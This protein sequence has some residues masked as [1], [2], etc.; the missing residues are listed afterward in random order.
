MAIERLIKHGATNLVVPGMPPVGCTPPVLAVFDAN[1][2]QARYNPQTGCL[3]EVNEL[4]IHHNSL[5]L[6]SIE[7]IQ[8]KYPEVEIIYADFFSPVM[9]MVE[10]PGK[11]GFERDVLT[12]CC[13]GPGRY[14]FR[15]AILCGEPGATKCEDPSARLFWDGAHLTEAANRYVADEWFSSINQPARARLLAV[16]N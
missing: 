3:D 6:E 1:S 9:E 14:H 13:G 8:A 12:V 15:Q 5:L 10:S 4:T 16:S 2:D 11:F 7:K